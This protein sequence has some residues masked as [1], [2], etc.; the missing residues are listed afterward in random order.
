MDK[1]LIFSEKY[2]KSKAVFDRV[3]GYVY[4]ESS[5]D[6]KFWDRI[7][8]EKNDKKY[9][10]YPAI[11]GEA[12]GKTVL[13]KHL[14]CTSSVLFFAID[15]DLDFI[16]PDNRDIALAFN[17]N[18][19]VIQT[20][21][22]SKESVI[23]LSEHLNSYIGKLWHSIEIEFNI[24]EHII[25]YSRK[26]HSIFRKFLFLKNYRYTT[27]SGKCFFKE[28]TPLA[29]VFNDR[30]EITNNI[31][32][33][34]DKSILKM[35]DTFDT[36]ISSHEDEF[37]EYKKDLYSKGFNE[38]T[39]YLFLSGHVIENQIIYKTIFNLYKKSKSMEF[40]N[41]RKEYHSNKDQRDMRITELNTVYDE[42]L[43]P[44][45]IIY[46]SDCIYNSRVIDAIRD[47]KI[48]CQDQQ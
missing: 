29:P 37:E 28:I 7:I 2:L 24:E 42:T 14:E 16:C 15:S 25:F 38:D 27:L 39:A 6:I 36:I 13:Y 22:Y 20:F 5:Q 18:D 26:I 3:N 47:H 30:F 40:K 19:N 35:S 4:I 34:V 8:N 32:K 46:S 1:S 21:L 23:Y 33:N 12:C 10:I 44:K 41:I 31:F 48:C 11:N 43:V 45:S 9:K 17:A